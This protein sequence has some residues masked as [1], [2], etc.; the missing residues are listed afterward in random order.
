MRAVVQR[1]TQAQVIVEETP[2]GN[3]GPGLVVL[4]GVG[5]GDTETDARFLADKIVNLRLFSDADDKMN[6]S[7]KD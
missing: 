4:L 1:V 2:V 6:L 7:V 3:C 5:H